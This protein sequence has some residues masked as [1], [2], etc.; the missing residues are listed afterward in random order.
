MAAAARTVMGPLGAGQPVTWGSLLAMGFVG[1]FLPSPSAVIVLPG[2]SRSDARGSGCPGDRLQGGHGRHAHGRRFAPPCPGRLG[3]ALFEGSA[4]PG[5]P[6]LD[7][8]CRSV[9][10]C[11]SSAWM[12]ICGWGLRSSF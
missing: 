1:A 9:Q 3:P 4:G 11:W 5:W 10:Q 8:T 7:A 12:P 6:T 2:P